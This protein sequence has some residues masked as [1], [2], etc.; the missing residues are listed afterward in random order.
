MLS[1]RPATICS[2]EQVHP[3]LKGTSRSQ[4]L[5]A[6]RR[7]SPS[8]EADC[9]SVTAERPSLDHSTSRNH[10]CPT[11]ERFRDLLAS[12]MCS[13]FLCWVD[14]LVSWIIPA[15]IL[16]PE[17]PFAEQQSPMNFH[18]CMMVAVACSWAREAARCIVVG[19]FG[20]ERGLP[21]VKFA[22][23]WTV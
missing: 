5:L 19:M 10:N 1:D 16:R 2:H 6:R 18:G 21:S 15:D 4:L 7:S 3:K 9:W 20:H 23:T 22:D 11:S 13:A 14:D 8:L 12:S 17:L